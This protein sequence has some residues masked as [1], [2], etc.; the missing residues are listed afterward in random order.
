M[1][2]LMVTLFWTLCISSVSAE[3]EAK[4]TAK[5]GE[6]V[7][8]PCRSAENKPVIVVQWRRPDLGS[9]Y[10][11]L[12]RDNRLD[13]GNQYP[14]YRNWVS[15]QDRQMKDGDV[16]L[17]LKD[18]AT[19][20]A[21]R[22]QCRV[23]NEGSFERKLISTVQLEVLPPDEKNITAKP[24]ENV[25]LPCR[26]AGSTAVIAVEW[27]RADL[28][29]G[30]VL[31]YRDGQINPGNQNLSYQNRVDLLDRQMKDRDVSLVLKNLMT[32][33]TGLYQCL[34]QNERSSDKKLISIVQLNVL[35]KGGEDGGNRKA[36]DQDG[37]VGIIVVLISVVLAAAVLGVLLLI[38]RKKQACF[39]KETSDPPVHL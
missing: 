24:G 14:S 10:V 18:V 37:S 2:S 23:Q 8:L 26:A 11:L 6:D 29:S 22:Y 38:C 20:D 5:P 34:V 25:T 30:Y 12:Y 1:V 9:Q 3:D 19:T 28:G 39:R 13:P 32:N 16:S 15:L 27:R 17:V 33:D 36:G 7:I 21:G 35:P 4:V 31:W